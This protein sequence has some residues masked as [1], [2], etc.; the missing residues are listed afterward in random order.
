MKESNLLKKLEK[1]QELK[2]SK[3]TIRNIFTEEILVGY[4][5]NLIEEL[6]EMEISDWRLEKEKLLT[7]SYILTASN[8]GVSFSEMVKMLEFLDEDEVENLQYNIYRTAEKLGEDFIDKT[9]LLN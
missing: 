7:L 4:P 6:K 1:L 2:S 8:Y 5:C 9:T 3:V